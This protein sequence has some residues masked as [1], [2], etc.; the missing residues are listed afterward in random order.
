MS[1]A[2]PTL[3][4]GVNR[5]RQLGVADYWIRVGYMGSDLN[6]V[7]EH[8]LTVSSGSLW[9][10]KDGGDWT[11]VTKGSSIWLFGI[12]GTF[13]WSQNIITVVLPETGGSSEALSLRCNE[14]FGYVEYLRLQLPERN[15][16]N[17]TFE[18]KDF[19]LGKHPDL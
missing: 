9:H 15:R 18:L 19:G 13:V 3:L 12:E 4:A 1:D 2:L 17:L 16:E 5:W 7:G 11:E 6:R 10:A 14:D 8:E